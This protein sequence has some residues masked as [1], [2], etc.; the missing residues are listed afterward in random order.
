MPIPPRTRLLSRPRLAAAHSP[1]LRGA[2]VNAHFS[3]VGCLAGGGVLRERSA[4]ACLLVPGFGFGLWG[5][6]S[7]W[8]TG[9]MLS[10]SSSGAF[11]G[12]FLKRRCKSESCKLRYGSVGCGWH[13]EMTPT[14]LL[15]WSCG[16]FRHD[17]AQSHSCTYCRQD[18]NLKHTS[19]HYTALTHLKKV[20]SF[21][22]LHI[23]HATYLFR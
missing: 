19:A 5:E 10:S 11:A 4:V 22:F 3:W 17:A 16:T 14:F 8:E 9:S 23:T 1:R 15:T 2:V 7:R 12:R 18:A 21:L 6:R 13:D 20:F